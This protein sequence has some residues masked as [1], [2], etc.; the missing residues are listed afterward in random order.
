MFVYA[1]DVSLVGSMMSCEI[2]PHLQS[3][4]L[5]F[6]GQVKD[7]VLRHMQAGCAPGMNWVEMIT[8]GEVGMSTD[9]LD[10]GYS[11]A[12]ILPKFPRFTIDHRMAVKHELDEV[13]HKL[14]SCKN[15]W[16][17]GNM[18]NA[19]IDINEMIFVK[20]GGEVWRKQLL[21]NSFTTAVLEQSADVIKDKHL[22][23]CGRL[24][25]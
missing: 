10:S 2:S 15:P 23:Q 5:L 1:N 11:I 7:L 19:K 21:P 4:T 24:Q 20:Y 25:R 9:L 22:Q 6:N 16:I 8:I 12:S 17:A 3:W 18:G 14:F 13:V